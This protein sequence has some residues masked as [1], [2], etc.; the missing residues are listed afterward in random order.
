[1]LTA[2]IAGNDT[3]TVN[4]ANAPAATHPI[5]V[6]DDTFVVTPDNLV[7]V[8]LNTVHSLLL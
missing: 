5:L 8:P 6:S 3:L 2:N 4:G 7:D 1:M